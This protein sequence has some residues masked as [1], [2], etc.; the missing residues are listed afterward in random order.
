VSVLKKLVDAL[1]SPKDTVDHRHKIGGMNNVIQVSNVESLDKQHASTHYTHTHTHKHMCKH[2]HVRNSAHAHVYTYIHQLAHLKSH[3]EAFAVS[4]MLSDYFA[5]AGL[6]NSV[7]F[8]FYRTWQRVL[9]KHCHMRKKFP[10]LPWGHLLTSST[11]RGNCCKIL[12]PFC[13]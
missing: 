8:T 10:L 11:S 1:G 2:T 4:F 7:A 12:L 6:L 5:L 3:A 13:R 9:K